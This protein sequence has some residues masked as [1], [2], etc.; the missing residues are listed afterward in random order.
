MDLKVPITISDELSEEVIQ[1]T[2]LLNLASGEI[3][4]VAYQDYDADAR[5]LPWESDDYEFTSGMLS[6]EGKDVEFRIDVNRTTGQ[7]WVSPSEL[8]EIKVRA[9]ALFAGVSGRELLANAEGRAPGPA[10]ARR[11]PGGSGRLH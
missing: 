8:L 11:G 2:G 6:N 1:S 9:A 4:R 5:G 7:Y 3:H 10:P